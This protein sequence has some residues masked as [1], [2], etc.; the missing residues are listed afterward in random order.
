MRLTCSERLIVSSHKKPGVPTTQRLDAIGNADI[1]SDTYDGWGET[2]TSD[3]PTVTLK[4][5]ENTLARIKNRFNMNSHNGKK[6]VYNRLT[7]E[8]DTSG[9]AGST[10]QPGGK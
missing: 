6:I 10:I 9:S 8:F 4:G 1:R 7:G 2:I 3:G 5:G